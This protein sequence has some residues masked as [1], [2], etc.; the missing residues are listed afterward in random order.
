MLL[1]IQFS[2][3][4][5]QKG[6]K[7]EKRN[8]LRCGC[9]FHVGGLSLAAVAPAVHKEDTRR[10]SHRRGRNQTGQKPGK[11]RVD[12]LDEFQQ[13]LLQTLFLEVETSS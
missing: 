1:N 2:R 12:L 10:C 9:V 6:V 13:G 4:I 5:I 11:T 8:Q 7:H 3:T